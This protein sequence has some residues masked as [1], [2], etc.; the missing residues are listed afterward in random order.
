MSAQFELFAAHTPFSILCRL[1]RT[2]TRR[3]AAIQL[4]D[5][6]HLSLHVALPPL[7]LSCL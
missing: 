2:V 6:C 4:A 5:A 3:S 7:L 1:P